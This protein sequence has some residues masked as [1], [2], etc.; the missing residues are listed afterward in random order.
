MTIRHFV[1]LALK[2]KDSHKDTSYFQINTYI[3][4]FIIFILVE[5]NGEEFDF[6]KYQTKAIPYIQ[7]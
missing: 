5:L 6:L 4:R 1:S 3:I 7:Q 2:R